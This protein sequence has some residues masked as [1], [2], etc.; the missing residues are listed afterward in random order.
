MRRKS[1]RK[2]VAG[3]IALTMVASAMGFV[4]MLNTSPAVSSV[5]AAEVAVVTDEENEELNEYR[6]ELK[7][8]LILI[9]EGIPALSEAVSSGIAALEAAESFDE[10]AQIWETVKTTLEI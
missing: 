4:T 1:I 10:L 5:S 6:D 2:A 7:S 9:G 3:V 8:D